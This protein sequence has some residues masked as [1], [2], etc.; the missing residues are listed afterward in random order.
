MNR[1]TF[2]FRTLG[3]LGLLGV[4]LKAWQPSPGGLKID[5][6]A[7]ELPLS[8][9]GMPGL[10]PGRVVQTF[11]PGSLV[12]GRVHLPA[13]RAMLDAGMKNLTGES[14]PAD[15]WARLI[16]KSDVVALKPNPSGSP[17]T[18]TSVPL[19]RE[20]IRNLNAVGVPNDRI[21]VY[22]RNSDQMDVAGYSTML[23]TGVRVIGLD[24]GGP[25]RS[26]YDL[27]VYCEMQCYDE[28]ETRSYMGAVV[29]REVTKI[30]NLPCLK[31]H[32]GA[33][34]TG[35]L[36]N[37][38]YG[39]FDNTARTHIIPTTFT[40]PVVA[41]MAAASPLRSKAVLHIMDGVRAVY[42]GGPIVRNPEFVWEAKT[43]LV[44]TDPVAMDRIELEIIEE[45]RRSVGAPS[46]WDR[47][48]E[49]L[50]STE[51]M[52]RDARKRRYVARGTGHVKTAAG[53]GLGRYELEQ[54]DHVKVNAG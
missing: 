38:A 54:I 26:G 49:N 21:I 50:G 24:Q 17:T 16:D 33:G 12:E 13:V 11:H 47:S 42:H 28:K 45:K 23:P 53:L 52:Q 39:S 29:S 27:S 36:K 7:P 25:K 2:V 5:V 48:P 35:A 20:V 44:A 41:V 6:Q 32:N 18:V 34:V 22:D 3:T 43:L 8:P 1:R 40:D 51:E 9:T 4:P 46:L 15:A 31:E 14:K 30:I 37:L 19:I 10:F